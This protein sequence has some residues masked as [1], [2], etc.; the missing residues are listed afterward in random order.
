MN[1]SNDFIGEATTMFED[2]Y[3]DQGD[4]T[5]VRVINENIVDDYLITMLD[6]NNHETNDFNK[7][8]HLNVNRHMYVQPNTHCILSYIEE[9]NGIQ[10]YCY[11]DL[12]QA[13]TDD[14]TLIIQVNSSHIKFE[15]IAVFSLPVTNDAQP[16]AIVGDELV[17]E[18]VD[19]VNTFFDKENNKLI[20]NGDT[21][22]KN[23]Q[24]QW[25]SNIN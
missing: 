13:L 2:T 19:F 10:N 5:H 11:I 7:C 3:I 16:K 8:H 15:N 9:N 20:F 23:I 18:E 17:D 6:A 4:G 22:S 12:K 25:L 1:N 14:V 24:L 21:L